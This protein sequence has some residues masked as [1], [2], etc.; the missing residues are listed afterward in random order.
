[1]PDNYGRRNAAGIDIRVIFEANSV[2]FASAAIVTYF[3]K[4][5][6]RAKYP[7][8]SDVAHGSSSTPTSLPQ[9]DGCSHRHVI[10]S[11]VVG[12]AMRDFA[13]RCS[14]TASID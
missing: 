7:K 13:T 8:L 5:E 4:A 1:M 9:A 12:R 10:L 6:N 11:A 14:Y 2:R 3:F